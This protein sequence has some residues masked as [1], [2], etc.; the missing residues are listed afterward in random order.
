MRYYTLR[1]VVV[2]C[3]SP[4]VGLA[5]L[6]SAVAQTSP[7]DIVRLKDGGMLR[8]TVIESLPG[9]YVR[10]QLADGTARELAY[11][12]VAYAGPV[13]TN[14]TPSLVAPS[15]PVVPNLQKANAPAFNEIGVTAQMIKL[16]LRSPDVGATF[17]LQ[18]GVATSTTAMTG[19]VI[20]ARGVA[21]I[22]SGVGT[23]MS[24][25]YDR[26]CTAPC[27]VELMA[28]TRKWKL[29][30]PNGDAAATDNILTQRNATLTATY[31]SRSGIRAVHSQ[32]EG[33]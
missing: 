19:T 16:R 5:F 11:D 1:A 15:A 18:K 29:E 6:S 3:L 10:I 24:E 4:L 12:Q 27:E 26:V 13:V 33:G 32:I 31:N 20:G 7:P 28:G 8:G 23:T 25:Q 30:L 2:C 9:K 22:T 21:A 17:S 14:P